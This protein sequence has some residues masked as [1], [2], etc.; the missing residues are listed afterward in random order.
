MMGGVGNVEIMKKMEKVL[1]KTGG[2]ATM[3]TVDNIHRGEFWRAVSGANV[4]LVQWVLLMGMVVAGWGCGPGPESVGEGNAGGDKGVVRVVTT[5]GMI[6][7][8]AEE[9]GGEFVE[10]EGLIGSG[11]DPHLYKP[12][13]RDVKKLQRADV[14]LYNGLKLEGKMEDVLDRMDGD[15]RVVRAICRELERRGD[16]LIREGDGH[17][18]PH[19]WMDVSGWMEATR[20]VHATLVEVDPDNKDGYDA[21]LEKFLKTLGELDDYCRERIATIPEG[22]RILVTAHDAFSY[23]ARAYGL[24]VRGIQG[25]STESEAGVREIEDLV[26]FLVEK[27]IPAV[28]V[29]SSVSDKNVQALIEGAGAQGHQVVIGGELF[30]DA[31]GKQGTWEG[32]YP[33]MIDHNITTLTRALGG[34]APEKGL[35]GKLSHKAGSADH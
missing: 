7:S 19:V 27:K 20:A 23:M 9:V 28:F 18:D 4:T 34:E 1:S 21:N 30:S 16:Y 17:L 32:T 10:V 8:L 12:T 35:F 2:V 22:Q 33:G 29:E 14:I 13:A 3:M 5:T 24:T 15:G 11:V 26:R 25:I 31:M 6:R